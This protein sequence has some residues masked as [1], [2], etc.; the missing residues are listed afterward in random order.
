[1]R[2]SL[3]TRT[4]PASS[5]TFQVMPKSSRFTFVLRRE[6][7]PLSAPGVAGVALEGHLERDLAGHAVDRQVAEDDTVS[8]LPLRALAAERR[9]GELLDVEQLGRLDVRVAVRVAGL[10][11][12]H[13][14]DDVDAGVGEPLGDLHRTADVGEASADLGDHE[15]PADERHVG[16]PRVD[17]PQSGGR[18]GHAVD[19]PGG[20]GVLCWS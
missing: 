17:L 1:M 10:H 6:H 13:A 2:I 7:R 15:V 18:N 8:A 16:V 11:A 20:G 4:P 5:A 14:D 19:V 9:L 3:L 12:G